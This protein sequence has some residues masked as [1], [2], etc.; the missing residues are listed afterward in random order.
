MTTT[1]KQCQLVCVLNFYLLGWN[2]ILSLIVFNDDYQP[3]LV[4]VLDCQDGWHVLVWHQTCLVDSAQQAFL[5]TVSNL[6]YDSE[7]YIWLTVNLG[8]TAW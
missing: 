2:I 6:R 7:C 3:Y 5:R 8:K 1:F 4:F